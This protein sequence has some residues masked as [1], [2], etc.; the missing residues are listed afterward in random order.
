MLFIIQF[1]ST[2]FTKDPLR[3]GTPWAKNQ[4]A[5]VNEAQRFK[6]LASLFCFH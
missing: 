6:E 2:T 4:R 5:E 3:G 1:S